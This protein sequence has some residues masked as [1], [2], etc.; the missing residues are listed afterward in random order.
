MSGRVQS[1]QLS[2]DGQH[3]SGLSLKSININEIDSIKY[4]YQNR[5]VALVYHLLSHKL[6]DSE[7][8]PLCLINQP[9]GNGHP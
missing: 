7:R 6:P 1:K 5:W 4:R 3:K 2:G 8:G 9:V